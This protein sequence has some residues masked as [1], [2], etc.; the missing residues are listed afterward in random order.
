M[1]ASALCA[2]GSQSV[3]L[4]RA[5]E[6]VKKY[7]QVVGPSYRVLLILGWKIKMNYNAGVGPGYFSSMRITNVVQ[8]SNLPGPLYSA[9]K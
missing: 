3:A 5:A 6:V 9:H 2:S 4:R 1:N 8:S 7:I